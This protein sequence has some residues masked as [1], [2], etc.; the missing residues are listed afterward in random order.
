MSWLA[1]LSLHSYPGEDN[2]VHG[3]KKNPGA[4]RSVSGCL[5]RRT[6][7]SLTPWVPLACSPLAG[8][9]PGNQL[10]NGMRPPT[11]AQQDIL[12]VNVS[13]P[14]RTLSGTV[15]PP[16]QRCAKPRLHRS[17][18]GYILITPNRIIPSPL[19]RKACTL[20]P[21]SFLQGRPMVSI[22]IMSEESQPPIVLVQ[23]N[24][25][26]ILLHLSNSALGAGLHPQHPSSLIHRTRK[27]QGSILFSTQPVW[28]DHQRASAI[29]APSTKSRVHWAPPADQKLNAVRKSLSN[30]NSL[31]LFNS[32]DSIQ[33]T[34]EDCLPSST[35]REY[36]QTTP[37]VSHR[38]MRL[39]SLW[40]YLPL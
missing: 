14:I 21:S 32:G 17:K 28:V 10:A 24:T 4:R 2:N 25:R 27:P 9:H 1:W 13:I 11:I 7:Q 26:E 38:I 40:C 31:A 29:S 16:T 12:G 35:F 37:S 34:F 18:H 20:E 22:I 3:D 39:S 30:S 6:S 15:E 33:H 36:S 19:L 23:P 8:M 5:L